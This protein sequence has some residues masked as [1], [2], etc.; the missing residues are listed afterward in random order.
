MMNELWDPKYERL[1][2]NFICILGDDII[3]NSPI[4]GGDE[5]YLTMELPKKLGRGRVESQYYILNIPTSKILI[6][7]QLLW[8]IP[9]Q[10]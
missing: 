4:P 2:I 8:W 9:M 6:Y 7:L 10:S 5:E 1:S 3:S